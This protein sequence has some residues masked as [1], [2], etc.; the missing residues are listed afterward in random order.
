MS[1]TVDPLRIL[2]SDFGSGLEH[3][4]EALRYEHDPETRRTGLVLGFHCLVVQAIVYAISLISPT[5]FMTFHQMFYPAVLLFRYL[6]PD[7]WDKL[8]MNT[9]RSLGSSERSDMVAKPRPE[10]FG[11]LRRHA[12]RFFK[13][14]LEVNV[15][16]TLIYRGSFLA[17]PRVILGVIAASH[18]LEFKGVKHA[19]WILLLL[20][21]LIGPRWPLWAVQ[22]MVLQRLFMYELL[23]PYLA[24]VQFSKWEERAWL[25]QHEVELHGFA[26][27]AWCLC[28]IPWIGLVALPFMFPAVAILL[29]RSCGS[30]ENTGQGRYGG[31]LIERMAPGIKDVALGKSRSVNGDWDKVT[32]ITNV[33]N[34][35]ISKSIPNAHDTKDESARYTLDSDIDIPATEHQ[36]ALDKELSQRRKRELVMTRRARGWLRNEDTTVPYGGPPVQRNIHYNAS[37]GG[38]QYMDPMGVIRPSERFKGE[39]F[40]MHNLNDQG[41]SRETGAFFPASAAGLADANQSPLDLA[42]R[43]ATREN[44]FL[45]V[46]ARRRAKGKKRALKNAL[47]RHKEGHGN[48]SESEDEELKDEESA[49]M[50]QGEVNGNCPLQREVPYGHEFLGHGRGISRG[51]GRGR[52]WRGWQGWPFSRGVHSRRGHHE[53]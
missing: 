30:L 40:T 15:A 14:F 44:R 8:F 38:V 6:R 34:T 49:N 31:N 53:P 42:T 17:L 52:G 47:H 22:T 21:S 13:A 7:P 37:P 39:D 5:C 24:R 2:V 29:T 20:S 26:F 32:V 35:S 36:I 3:L 41:T 18:I 25:S 46:N 19:L 12:H 50:D 27:G 11:Q 9:I 51:L 4:W 16:F 48:T 28:S 43:A 45:A 23:Q 10:Y 33:H 1:T